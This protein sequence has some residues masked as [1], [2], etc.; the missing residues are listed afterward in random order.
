LSTLALFLA[1]LLSCTDMVVR[2]QQEQAGEVC[3]G[4]M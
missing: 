2:R 1:S 4:S 3:A